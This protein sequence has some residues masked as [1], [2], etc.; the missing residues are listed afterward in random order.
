MLDQR[1][2]AGVERNLRPLGR[3][4]RRAGFTAD[5]LTLL[6]LGASL[7]TA[8]AI[9]RGRFG[10]AC[11]GLALAGLTD[12]LDGAVA[13]AGGTAGPRGAFFDS[14]ADRLSDAVMLG[15][16]TWWLADHDPHLT[17]LAVAVLTTAFLTSYERARA[18]GLGLAGK[19]G[20][21]ERAERMVLLGAGLMFDV[22]VPVLW[23]LLV[24]SGV[25]VAQRFAKVWHQATPEEAR[26]AGFWVTTRPARSDE[27]RLARW[28][29][30]TGA[31]DDA[32]RLSRWLLSSH[33]PRRDDEE[34]SR[35]ARWWAGSRPQ[36]AVA[37]WQRRRGRTRP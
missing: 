2:R 9:A 17:V 4:L 6:G 26:R 10:V 32:P 36:A 14:V 37:R 30:A 3:H 5:Q 11:V 23:I 1:W 25:T 31:H 34:E 21:M 22:L 7:L 33:P 27:S 15:G 35:L 19:G 20:L 24:L 13:K 28:R 18:E 12:V 16:V 29:A 8:V